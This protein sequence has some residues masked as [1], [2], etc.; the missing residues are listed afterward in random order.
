MK[1]RFIGGLWHMQVRPIIDPEP[2]IALPVGVNRRVD[3]W[4]SEFV[5]HKRE[6]YHLV[7]VRHEVALYLHEQT[8]LDLVEKLTMMKRCGYCGELHD[9]SFTYFGV[10]MLACP[11]Y[12]YT[13]P[14]FFGPGLSEL[15]GLQDAV[16]DV[17]SYS[18]GGRRKDEKTIPPLVS[19]AAIAAARA[20]AEAEAQV[21]ASILRSHSHALAEHTKPTKERFLEWRDAADYRHNPTPPKCTHCQRPST[22]LSYSL[23]PECINCH[24][25]FDGTGYVFEDVPYKN[26]THLNRAQ[27]RFI[28]DVGT[29]AAYAD[30]G[31][32]LAELAD[33]QV[34]TTGPTILYEDKNLVIGTYS[35]SGTLSPAMQA[36]AEAVLEAMTGEQWVCANHPPGFEITYPATTATCEVCGTP[37]GE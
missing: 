2:T 35:D 20:R 12:P 18:Y 1:A 3:D 21:A 22:E 9:A 10:P 33:A 11:E 27:R 8:A 29:R 26:C 16:N 31:K 5:E 24:S 15:L 14:A 6:V 34:E 17:V 4:R 7:G 37:K 30:G 23:C 19:G 25:W 32:R 36:A 13:Q 28:Q